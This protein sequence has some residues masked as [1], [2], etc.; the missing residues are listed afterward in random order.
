MPVRPPGTPGRL[1]RLSPWLLLL[2]GLAAPL[3]AQQ[4][5]VVA[6][7][8]QDARSGTG[9]E[10]ARVLLAG[11]PLA[12]TT[13]TNGRF[14]FADVAPGRYGL[15][16]A[17]V[18]YVA[19]SL[20][21]VTVT[22]GDTARVVVAMRPAAVDLPGI[23]VTASRAPE[24]VE[25]APASVAVL[26][27]DEVIARNVNTVDGALAFVPG[28]AFNGPG[29]MDIRGSTGS[30]GGIGSRVLT[31]IDGHPALSGDGGEIIFEA[32]PLL[33]LDQIE[34]VKGAASAL[35]GSNALGGVVNLVTS[36]VGD[37][38][39][40]VVRAHIG[41][42]QVPTQYQ[43]TNDAL[44][45]QGLS[46]QHSRRFGSVGVR[47]TADRETSDGFQ[48]NG[49]YGRWFLR[50][51]LTSAPE[52]AH[53]WDAYV[54]WSRNDAGDFLAWRSQSQPFEVTPG[55]LGDRSV[56]SFLLAGATVTPIATSS[57]LL[58]VSPYLNH[59]SNQNYFS[60]NQD[61]HDATRGG[62]TVQLSLSAGAR[63]ALTLGA[64]GAGTRVSSNFLGT[65]WLWDGAVFG[66]DE[67]TLGGGFK[68][69][70]GAR[71][72]YHDTNEGE[73]EFSLNPKL[74]LV[75]HKSDR[76]SARV[77]VAR[78]YR[79]PSAI[80]QFVS[81][82]QFG[83]RV[84]PNPALHGEHAWTGELGT[85]AQPAGWLTTDATL[86]WSEYR[87]LIGPGLA[88]A[89]DGLVAQFQNVSRARVRGL[90]LAAHSTL[91]PERL[92][93]SASYLFLDTRD[94][95]TQFAL[96]YRSR[97]NLTGTLE[98]LRGLFDVDLRWRSRVEQVLAYP[99]DPRGAITIVDLRAAYRIL[100]TVVQAKVGNLF[101]N[102]Y[103]DVQER[104]PGA[105][106][107][108]SLTLYRT[109]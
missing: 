59:N 100:G 108:L 42:Y 10:G 72:D 46:L 4:P 83:F 1:R 93:L 15:A 41:F 55:S 109:F 2:S 65:P 22:S 8:V 54:I 58:R 35:Y 63:H 3:A 18:G 27:H 60:E 20:P 13:G 39:E 106:R 21:D 73:S 43:F 90:D 86:F 40:T 105:P 32:L 26:S 101:Q 48:Q 84:V 64:D 62:T 91:L 34:V 47:I 53:P 9:L 74:G 70:F 28:V 52:A 56:Y 82:V 97:H 96:P 107:S 77:S 6:G 24:R 36:S 49:Q 5:G 99:L 38:P 57:T 103:A 51:K 94:L 104:V 87:D 29:Q 71:L 68:G 102:V 33:D 88:L 79:A 76:L 81:T 11:T 30:A 16:V 98:V 85:A 50:T 89:R 67:V 25:D 14:G 78:G 92:D 17:A 75:W 19:D 12:T 61:Y 95:D 69:A 23:V 80:E 37:R 7:Q 66:Q 44:N 31:L 45:A